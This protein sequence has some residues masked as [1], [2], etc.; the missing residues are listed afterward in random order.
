MNKTQLNTIIKEE[1]K[2]I[3]ED[4][5]WYEGYKFSVKGNILNVITTEGKKIDAMLYWVVFDGK[6]V[7]DTNDD[8]FED[9]DDMKEIKDM[10]KYYYKGQ[11]SSDVGTKN[12]KGNKVYLFINSHIGGFNLG[13]TK[14]YFGGSPLKYWKPLIWKAWEKRR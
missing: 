8:R 10:K 13:R 12:I 4:S 3:K 14:Q 2:L 7:I 5:D 9:E 6:K 1:I 11:K